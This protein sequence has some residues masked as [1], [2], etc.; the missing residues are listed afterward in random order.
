M[1]E[2]GKVKVKSLRVLVGMGYGQV[3]YR[4]YI[5]RVDAYSDARAIRDMI[6]MGYH[7]SVPTAG[8]G[9]KYSMEE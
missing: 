5:R 7:P 1:L 4:D 2:Y 6:K 9:Y 8:L 3:L